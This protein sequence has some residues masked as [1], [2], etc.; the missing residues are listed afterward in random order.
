MQWIVTSLKAGK[1]SYSRFLSTGISTS[2]VDNARLSSPKKF[3]DSVKSNVQLLFN[4]DYVIKWAKLPS[5]TTM[6]RT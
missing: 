4:A 1:Q 3:P 5:N 6:R 2:S